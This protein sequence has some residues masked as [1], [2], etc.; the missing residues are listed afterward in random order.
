MDNVYCVVY[1]QNLNAHNPSLSYSS[2]HYKQI[3]HH[4]IISVLSSLLDSLNHT[5]TQFI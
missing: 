1:L 2:Y 3:P 4:C 5:S